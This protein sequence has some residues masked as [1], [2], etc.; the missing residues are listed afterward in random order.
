MLHF[1]RSRIAA[2]VIA[3]MNVKMAAPSDLTLNHIAHIAKALVA[4]AVMRFF[5]DDATDRAAVIGMTLRFRTVTITLVVTL[6]VSALCADAKP[7]TDAR[8]KASAAH[9]T[10]LLEVIVILPSY[11]NGILTLFRRTLLIFEASMMPKAHPLFSTE[12]LI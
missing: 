7:D 2:Q 11:Q 3:D 9:S 8:A 10:F 4:L 1:V 5:N 12:K 6:T